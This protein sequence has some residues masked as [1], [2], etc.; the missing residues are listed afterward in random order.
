[1]DLVWDL[2]QTGRATWLRGNHEQ[3]LI[4]DLE[5]H[6]VASSQERLEPTR[7]RM[8]SWARAA[9]DSG[10]RDCNSSPSCIEVTAGAPPTPDSMLM[11]SRISPFAIPFWETYDGRFGL[12]V[13]GHTPRPQVER[14]GAHRADRYRG[15]LRRLSVGLLPGNGCCCAGSGGCNGH[16]LSQ[17]FGS[18]SKDRAVLSANTGS[19]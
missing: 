8:A 15:G 16:I 18:T 4:H 2:I 3:D 6:V 12:V 19:C 17:A 11:A 10:S 7:H 9:R 13:V 1:M 5:N 14:L